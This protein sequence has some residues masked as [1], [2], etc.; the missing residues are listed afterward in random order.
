MPLNLLALAKKEGINIEWWH[1][2]PPLEAIYWAIPDLP[3]FIGL[4]YVLKQRSSA[5]FRCVLAEEM[6]HHFTTSTNTLI[7]KNS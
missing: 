1:F 2:S 7:Q 3:P 4:S 6:G 5:Y